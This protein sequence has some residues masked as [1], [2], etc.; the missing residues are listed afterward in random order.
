[1]RR[2][3]W[4]ADNII[5]ALIVAWAERKLGVQSLRRRIAALAAENA[6]LRAELAKVR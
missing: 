2:V 3:V 5:A 4:H 6:A 1:V